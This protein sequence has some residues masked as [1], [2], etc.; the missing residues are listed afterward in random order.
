[1]FDPLNQ[2]TLR[3]AGKRLL[4]ISA[5]SLQMALSMGTSSVAAQ[6]V[7]ERYQLYIARQDLAS[8]LKDVAR[9]TG[10][11]IAGF[12]DTIDGH[13]L[14]GPVS[15][16]LSIEETLR[17]LLA[18][19]DLGYKIVNDHT[20]AVVDPKTATSAA[21]VSIP[22]SFRVAGTGVDNFTASAAL[23][24]A[25]SRLEEVTVTAQRRTQSLQDVPISVQV[26]SADRLES[27]HMEMAMDLQ[28]LVPGLVYGEVGYSTPYLRGVGNNQLAFSADPGVSTYVDG[29]YQPG[30]SSSNVNEFEL[31]RV[32]VLKGPQTTLY[33]RNA[34]GG[35]ISLVTRDP[36][37]DF[38]SSL[39]VGTGNLRRREGQGF[40]SGGISDDLRVGLYGN[41]SQRDAYSQ[42]I[43]PSAPNTEEVRS[44]QTRVKAIWEPAANL[45]LTLVGRYG[46]VEDPQ[47]M[48]WRDH[49]SNSLAHVAF[50][51]P[52]LPPHVVS[53]DAAVA[54][55][56]W[57][58][59]QSLRADY[60]FTNDVT[61]VSISARA[62]SN[63]ILLSDVDGSSA[64]IIDSGTQGQTNLNYTQEVQLLSSANGR[65][66]WILGMLFFK[67]E[68]KQDVYINIPFA[69][70]NQL[71][72]QAW[73]GRSR[74]PYG[75]ATFKVT[76]RVSVAA[77]ARYVTEERSQHTTD[78]L[79]SPLLGP[80]SSF[81]K[82]KYDRL[83]P[84]L[85]L[86]Y[87]Q[88]DRLLYATYAEGF[89][90]GG[91]ADPNGPTPL[92]PEVVKNYEAGAKLDLFD[93]RVRLSLAV[94]R[95]VYEH[96]V[97]SALTFPAGV[98][99]IQNAASAKVKGLELDIA[100]QVS[101]NFRVGAAASF[102]NARY[103]EFP[104]AAAYTS[105]APLPGLKAVQ[106][107]LSGH[108]MENSPSVSAQVN[109]DYNRSLGF[110]GSLEITANYHY[111]SRYNLDSYGGTSQPS[112]GLLGSSISYV[113]PSGRWTVTAWGKNLAD[114][115]YLSGATETAFG[116]V[117]ID[118]APR[119]YGLNISCRKGE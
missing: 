83:N 50:G 34:I 26:F 45:K 104:A 25:P 90:S 15:G 110:G 44:Q 93:S 35:V 105:N 33:G 96:K 9:Q 117:A 109:L 101:N 106:L 87:K 92:R 68:R 65:L 85:T 47:R 79:L 38:D 52:L 27:V 70:Q 2:G 59:S 17:A 81:S 66:T 84:K 86:T 80:A 19:H 63:S 89:K 18:P 102:L 115:D 40:I 82:S 116:R 23:A 29:V 3:K 95:E 41:W 54:S 78:T 55:H 88:P 13:V 6:S 75:E 46:D 42:N 98:S 94:F 64:P 60:T 43:H 114:K 118:G 21:T 24:V 36:G 22:R 73:A 56:T 71:A 74:E 72:S 51:A 5:L 7:S 4:P 112:H 99:V 76:D 28:G 8:A 69:R 97:V 107:N 57:D 12:S 103:D 91:A 119:T 11:Q 67:E 16:S 100:T 48:L 58:N 62:R 108:R 32:E 10:L 113:S 53:L 20:V 61:F 39:T 1:M 31:E 14:V 111:S 37:Y 77:G 49:Y 30:V